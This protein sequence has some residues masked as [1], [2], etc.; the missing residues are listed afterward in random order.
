MGLEYS[1]KAGGVALTLASTVI[2]V[3][4]HGLAVAVERD[5]L[6]PDVDCGGCGQQVN[7]RLSNRV[8]ERT[9]I[10]SKTVSEGGGVLLC[11]SPYYIM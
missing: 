10:T 4:E 2:C 11:K 6:G 8:F 1:I 3:L 9:H 7:L 5:S